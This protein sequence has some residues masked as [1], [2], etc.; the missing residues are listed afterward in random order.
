MKILALDLGTKTGLAYNWQPHGMWNDFPEPATTLVLAKPEE[1]TRWIKK[2]MDRRSDPRVLR[3]WSFLTRLVSN[4]KPDLVVFEDVQFASY[5]KQVQLWSSLRAAVWIA[6]QDVPVIECVP[7]TT[8]KKFASGYG[9][10]DK[11]L[12]KKAFVTQF[13][14]VYYGQRKL[15]DNA[16]DALWLL[17]WAEHNLGR[18]NR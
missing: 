4:D 7:V 10:A 2:R 13:G 17:R 14:G 1:V 18:L 11:A 6:C 16:I 5:T 15:D 3:L 8:L 9:G 12:M